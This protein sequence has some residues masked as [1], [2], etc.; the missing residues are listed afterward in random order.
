MNH[1]CTNSRADKLVGGAQQNNMTPR[2]LEE[3]E[4]LEIVF[5]EVLE[6]RYVHDIDGKILSNVLN[7]AQLS[8]FRHSLDFS[9]SPQK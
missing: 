2:E 1:V 3:P 8:W 5:F 7:C 9:I 4:R 6:Q